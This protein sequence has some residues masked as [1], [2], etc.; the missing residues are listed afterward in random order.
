MNKHAGKIISKKE[1]G[2]LFGDVLVKKEIESEFLRTLCNKSV[3]NMMFKIVDSEVIILGDNRKVIYPPEKVISEADVFS[4]YSKSL[5]IEL[6]EKGGSDK[7]YIEERK[8]V[9]TISNGLYVLEFSVPCPPL[10]LD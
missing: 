4:R 2:E 7:T 1:A 10:C 5:V 6:L 3:E 8:E 9:L